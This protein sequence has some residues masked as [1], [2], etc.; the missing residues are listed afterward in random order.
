MIINNN[1]GSGFNQRDNA[2]CI[3]WQQVQLPHKPPHRQ[4][5][6]ISMTTGWS[7]PPLNFKI[8]THSFLAS[9]SGFDMAMIMID[10]MSN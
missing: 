6:S 2:Q 5:A 8:K 10:R 9:A 3:I 1:A 4:L 7:K